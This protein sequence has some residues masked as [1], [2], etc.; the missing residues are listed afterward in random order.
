MMPNSTALQLPKR[1]STVVIAAITILTFTGL[2]AG[3]LACAVMIMRNSANMIDDQRALRAATAASHA[4]QEKLAATVRDNA[5]WDDAYKEVNSA[6]GA[7]WSYENWGKVS[8]DYPLYDGVVVEG[9]DGDR[10][11]A[12]LKGKAFD[13]EQLFGETF[14]KQSRNAA[15]PGQDPVMTYIETD[16]KIA[17]VGSKAIQPFSTVGTEDSYSVLTFFKILNEE[18]VAKMASEYQLDGLRLASDPPAN[19]LSVPLLNLEGKPVAHLVWPSQKPGSRVYHEVQ[20]HLI[21]AAIL[22]MAFMLIVVAGSRQEASMLRSLAKDAHWKATHDNLTGLL[23]R[24]GLLEALAD[25]SRD[26]TLHLIDLDGFKGVNDAWGHAVGDELLKMVAD[27]LLTSHPDVWKAARF[28][29]DEFAL[30]QRGAAPP[31]ELNSAVLHALARPFE[32]DGRTIEMGAS[33]GH[34]TVT[35]KVAPLEL[36][37]RA[38]IAL[39]RAKETGKG[40]SCEFT[41]ELDLEREQLASL[42][43]LLRSAIAQN[44]IKP[45]FQ[46][47]ISSKTGRICGVEA[48]ARWDTDV[49]CVVPDV[50]IPLAERAGLIDALGMQILVASVRAVKMMNDIGL[51]VNVS[52]L[53]LCNPEFVQQVSDVLRAEAFDAHRLTFEITEGVLISNPD[54]A[55]RAID[56]LKGLGVKFALDD[57]GCGFA[58]IGALRQFGFDRMKIDK[59]LVWAIDDGDKGANVLDATIALAI[60]LGIPVTAEGIE[61]GRQADVLRA[62]GCDQLQGYLVGKPMSV[63]ALQRLVVSDKHVA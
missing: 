23:N 38:D 49:G 30:V 43:S 59:S 8:E 63:A 40:R 41:A 25:L 12:Y 11:S 46:P 15:G 19:F 52:P 6:R 48:L 44:A 28:G 47:L 35:L 62:A 53:Q 10:I 21:V 54:Q 36:M 5:V 27:R 34:A 16:G 26:A 39:Y 31:T 18:V 50:F 20:P 29:G 4:I 51:S 17:L 61:T 58:S 56:A 2:I 45:L 24:S 33:I 42:E 7:D 60:A 37:R 14:I 1:T 55:R 22:L 13:P 32:I 3:L 57:F 9:G